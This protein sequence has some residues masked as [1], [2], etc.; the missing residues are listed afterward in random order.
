MQQ[1]KRF[2]SLLCISFI[3]SSCRNSPPISAKDEIALYEW[4]ITDISGNTH[5]SVSFRDGKINI[6]DNIIN[7]TN[8]CTVNENTI[9]VNSQNYGTVIF[10]YTVSGNTLELE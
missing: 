10:N 8:E 9:T 6:S 3:L 7:F 4:T 2:L 1:L 5:G